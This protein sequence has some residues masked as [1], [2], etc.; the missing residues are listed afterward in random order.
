MTPGA[1]HIDCCVG[2]MDDC[3][4]LQEERTPND[5]VVADVKTGNFERQ[6]LPVLVLHCPTRYL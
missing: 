1:R 3:H 6:Y 2:S 5:T 4:E